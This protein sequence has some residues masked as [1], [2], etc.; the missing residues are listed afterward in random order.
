MASFA[1][2]ITFDQR[3]IGLS[4]RSKGLPDLETRVDDLRAVLDAASFERAVLWGGGNDGGALCAMFAATHPD[5][6]MALAFWNAAPRSAWAPDYPWGLTPEIIERDAD[7]IARGWGGEP[8]GIIM[9]LVGGQSSLAEDDAA[10]RWARRVMRYMAAP[11]DMMAFDGMW[12]AIDFR[13]ILPSIHVPTVLMHSFDGEDRGPVSYMAERIAGSEAIAF[14]SDDNFAIWPNHT[15]EAVAA[16]HAFIERVRHEEA[17]L[18]RV[19]ATVLFT[20]IVDSTSVAATMGDADWR[21]LLA[22]H[23]RIAKGLI[24]RHRGVWRKSTG[25]GAMA[26]FDGPARAVRSAQ[27]IVEAVRPLGIEI[28]VGAHTGEVTIMDDDIAGLGVHVAARVAAL[29]GASEVWTSS[30]VRDLTAGS[31]LTFE[32]TGEHQLKGVPDRWRLYRVAN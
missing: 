17:E 8:A 21:D 4:D 14:A 24:A 16:L 3:G 7:L 9:Q 22:E 5:R 18:D 32:D 23:D 29:A 11:G 31:G 26:T 15:D 25:D 30:T 13:E 27:A 19:L 1:R 2:V 10:V 28:R 12:S 6:V 20:D